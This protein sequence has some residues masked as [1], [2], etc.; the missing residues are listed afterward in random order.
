MHTYTDIHGHIFTKYTDNAHNTCDLGSSM[1]TVHLQLSCGDA[2]QAGPPKVGYAWRSHSA[3]PA[4]AAGGMS[5]ERG[6]SHPRYLL[7]LSINSVRGMRHST[8][9]LVL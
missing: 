2:V 8:S 4:S 1:H 3:A 7:P 6:A 5:T 9:D